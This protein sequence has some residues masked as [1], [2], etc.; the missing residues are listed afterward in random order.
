MGL[1]P[2]SKWIETVARTKVSAAVVKTQPLPR[3]AAT[4]PARNSMLRGSGFWGSV[5]PEAPTTSAPIRLIH[6]AITNAVTTPRLPD[7]GSAVYR[8]GQVLTMPDGTRGGTPKTPEPLLVNTIAEFNKIV[9]RGGTPQIRQTQIKILQQEMYTK[10]QAERPREAVITYTG[11]FN[12]RMFA[13]SK[14]PKPGTPTGVQGDRA[15]ES[16]K[17]HT[18]TVYATMVSP[19]QAFNKAAFARTGGSG[20]AR[21]PVTLPAVV[22]PTATSTAKEAV[23]K[24]FAW[25]PSSIEGSTKEPANQIER[26]LLFAGVAVLGFML[27]RG[28]G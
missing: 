26:L 10:R 2:A 27:I 13:M 3:P 5:L 28:S 21:A 7:R 14:R 24:T 1:L 18:G 12:A 16:E 22:A 15:A 20:A 4:V 19:L 8:N 17:T 6:R 11:G 25:A 23:G 9:S